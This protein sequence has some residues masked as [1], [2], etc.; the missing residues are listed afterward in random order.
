M[1]ILAVDDERSV[2]RLIQV[3]LERAGYEVVAAYDGREALQKIEQEAPDLIILD[4]MMPYVDGFE[5]LK[6][7]KA[8]P[9]T[10]RIPVIMLTVRA[11]D[12]DIL[13][14]YETGAV[15]YLTK[16]FG[17]MEILATVTD[18]LGPPVGERP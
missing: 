9:E 12:A 2:V 8:N 17:A 10:S 5:V 7:L 3:N 1:R 11:Q 13:Y 16:P 15:R 4:V 18:I 6:N 14:G